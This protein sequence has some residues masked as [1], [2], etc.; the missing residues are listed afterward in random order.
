MAVVIGLRAGMAGEIVVAVDVRVVVVVDA[1]VGA[2]V[3]LVVGVEIGGAVG[4]LVV[5]GGA[6]GGTK[7]RRHTTSGHN[8]FATDS[9][10]SRG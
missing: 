6:A 5:A 9:H 3:G 2:V 1:A 7:L 8:F 4:V 10:G